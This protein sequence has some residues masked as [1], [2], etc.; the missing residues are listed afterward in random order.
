MKKILTALVAA[1]ILSAG[2]CKSTGEEGIK[3]LAPPV[4]IPELSETL[5][6]KPKALPPLKGS[7]LQAINEAGAEADAAYNNLS[8][9]YITLLDIYTCVQKTVNE[10]KDPKTC[11]D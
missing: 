6:Q 1:A 9:R 8:F 2:S 4:Q 3:N 10:K 7:S 5:K 11:T